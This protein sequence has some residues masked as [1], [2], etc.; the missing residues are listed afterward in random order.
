MDNQKTNQQSCISV[1]FFTN[2]CFFRFCHLKWSRLR[3][4]IERLFHVSDVAAIKNKKTEYT[5]RFYSCGVENLLI[6]CM[7]CDNNHTFAGLFRVFLAANVNK[8]CFISD[9]E[10]FISNFCS[11]SDI[12]S[13]YNWVYCYLTN[14]T[15]ITKYEIYNTVIN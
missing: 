13:V 5:F 1:Y 15:F 10:W 14:I 2:C 3:N 6:I 11:L 8:S 7:H 9:A 4:N 12:I